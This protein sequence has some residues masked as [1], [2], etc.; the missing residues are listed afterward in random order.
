MK[1]G[2]KSKDLDEEVAVAVLGG[3]KVKEGSRSTWEVS[4]IVIQRLDSRIVK[5]QDSDDSVD[6]EQVRVRTRINS[7]YLLALLF[8]GSSSA[9]FKEP[10]SNSSP[11]ST[12]ETLFARCIALGLSISL[13]GASPSTSSSSS[14]DPHSSHADSLVW[15]S[16]KRLELSGHAS[17][18]V[19]GLPS[20]GQYERW[21]G[22][23]G[24]RARLAEEKVRGKVAAGEEKSACRAGIRTSRLVDGSPVIY[25]DGGDL[26]DGES[27]R[28]SRFRVL[29]STRR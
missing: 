11:L 22:G 28:V 4:R 1:G 10:T 25:S 13:I 19:V 14:L 12:S 29:S 24:E 20:D 9:A 16:R 6:E 21:D 27:R 8:S 2:G 17:I 15:K 7:T 18:A 23:A 5:M 26:L 3:S